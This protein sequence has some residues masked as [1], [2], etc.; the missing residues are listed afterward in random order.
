[1][2]YALDIIVFLLDVPDTT[3][4]MCYI[5]LMFYIFTESPQLILCII[6]M[7]YICYM[8]QE[9][10]DNPQ[11]LVCIVIMCYICYMFQEIA[12]SPQLYTEG[13]NRF[14]VGQGSAGT[15]WFLSILAALADKTDVLKQ[16]RIS[17]KYTVIYMF[18]SCVKFYQNSNEYGVDF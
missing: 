8:L 15:C 1:M 18:H 7:C 13:S 4:C 3:D 2:L 16:V 5:I 10:T 12:E 9:I 6:T 11:L 17:S 14:D